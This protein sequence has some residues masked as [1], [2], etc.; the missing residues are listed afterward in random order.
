[1]NAEGKKRGYQLSVANALWGQKGYGFLPG[2]LKLTKDNYGAGLQE[3][4]F[5]GAT[6]ESRQRINKWVEEKTKEKIKDLIKKGMLTAETKLV[7]TNAIHFKGDWASQFKKDQTREEAFKVSAENSSKVPMMHQK[8]LFGYF[9]A[10]DFQMLEMPYEGKEL[11]MVV[12]LPKKVDGLAALE[13]ELTLDTLTG[14]IGKLH[15]TE[16]IVSFPKFQTTAEFVLNDALLNLGMKKAFSTAADFSGMN[17]ES[18]LFI[19][20]VIHK[21]FVDVNEQGTE[22][23]AA[24]A[25]ILDPSAIKDDPVFRADHPFLFLIRDTRSGSILFLGRLMKP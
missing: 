19:S 25:V 20:K 23:A 4:D 10:R 2:F 16:V 15:R 17:G 8:G 18:D 24:T 6:E 5:S 9:E 1:L 13:K 12:L 7:L 14:W 11:S 3:I 22:A 21:A